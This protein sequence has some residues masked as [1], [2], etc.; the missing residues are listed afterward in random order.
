[1]ARVWL[2]GAR[3]RFSYLTSAE[4]WTPSYDL[5]WAGDATGEL[6]LHARLPTPEKG[7]Q[8]LVSAGTV[9]QGLAP[10]AVRGDFPTI[11]RFP[12]LLTNGRGEEPPP[13]FAFAPVPGTL[14]PGEA[15]VYWRGE[16]LGSGRFAGAGAAELLLA[17]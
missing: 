5:R 12:L 1:V 2:T 10:K 7:V 16:Y 17:R 4:R 6:L 15:S 14:P 9:T 8:Y 11:A 13:S 3:A